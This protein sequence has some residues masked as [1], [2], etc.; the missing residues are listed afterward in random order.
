MVFMISV[1]M[2]MTEHVLC[3]G[4]NEMHVV[5]ISINFQTDHVSFKANIC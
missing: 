2:V 4:R 5:N 1:C 3:L